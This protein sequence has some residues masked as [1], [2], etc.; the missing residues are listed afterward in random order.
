MDNG[1]ITH[2]TRRGGTI[3]AND[4]RSNMPQN[5]ASMQA[6]FDENSRGGRY[7]FHHNGPC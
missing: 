4:L 6:M 1:I 5:F 2:S 7:E 3:C